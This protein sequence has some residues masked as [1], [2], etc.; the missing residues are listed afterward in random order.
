MPIRKC[1]AGGESFEPPSVLAQTGDRAELN[2]SQS[3]LFLS[4]RVIN[5]CPFRR[6]CSAEGFYFLT[7]LGF[8]VILL[9]KGVPKHNAKVLPEY[10]RL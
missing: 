6:L 3:F 10:G 2:D 5:K 4:S 9:F 8:V 7:F 1:I